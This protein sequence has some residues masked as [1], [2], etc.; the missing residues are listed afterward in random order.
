MIAHLTYPIIVF[1]FLSLAMLGCEEKSPP[2]EAKVIRNPIAQADTTAQ[3]PAPQ[4]NKASD[5]IG[6]KPSATKTSLEDET[7]AVDLADAYNPEGRLDPFQ[8][9]FQKKEEKEAKTKRKKKFIPQGPL[10]MVD[11]SQLK[12]AGIIRSPNGHKALV[13]EASGK[14]YIVTEGTYMGN[15]GGKIITIGNNTIVV[16]EP[17]EDNLG[18]EVMKKREM[19]INRPAGEK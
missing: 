17:H 5:P 16:E 4:T 6:K 18:N 19:K 7:L 9:L 11:L 12:V 3:A 2:P 13:E 14:G 15:R 10:Q 8:P 1:V